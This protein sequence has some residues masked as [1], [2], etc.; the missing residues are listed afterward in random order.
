MALINIGDVVRFFND[1]GDREYV[2]VIDTGVVGGLGEVTVTPNL[3]FTPLAQRPYR[4]VSNIN[5]V[6]ANSNQSRFSSGYDNVCEYEVSFKESAKLKFGRRVTPEVGTQI[7]NTI[8]VTYIPLDKT[9]GNYYNPNELTRYGLRSFTDEIE[10][11]LTREQIDM[12]LRIIMNPAPKETFILKS[13]RRTPC[14]VGWIVNFNVP[15]FMEGS[16]ITT[17]VTHYLIK[18]KINESYRIE[19]DIEFSNY[20]YELSDLLNTF[21]NKYQSLKSTTDE[22][23]KIILSDCLT[24]ISGKDTTEIEALIPSTPTANTATNITNSSFTANWSASTGAVGYFITYDG[25]DIDVGN[26][27]YFDFIEVTGLTHT[28][29]VK[30]YNSKGISSSSLTIDVTLT[31]TYELITS[32]NTVL[33]INFNTVSK[34]DWDDT[35][36]NNN[37]VITL[38][39]GSTVS[40]TDNLPTQNYHALFSGTNTGY[41]SIY[42]SSSY[43]LSGS[44]FTIEAIVRWRS[45]NGS[46]NGLCTK[47]YPGGLYKTGEWDIGYQDTDGF[48]PKGLMFDM[49]DGAT[50]RLFTHVAE[51]LDLNSLYYLV[52]TWKQSTKTL[53]HYINKVNKPYTIRTENVPGM[54]EITPITSFRTMTNPTGSPSVGQHIE[55]LLGCATWDIINGFSNMDMYLFAIHKEEIT[56]EQITTNYYNFF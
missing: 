4:V 21:K 35:T 22:Q 8:V 20:R 48:F 44:D 2:T 49:H 25:V 24:F 3:T 12:I 15:Y 46:F 42:D 14:Q 53:K 26:V 41:C 9:G 18:N 52:I 40:D 50:S 36:S 28:Y 39:A 56:Q 51:E 54:T 31:K 6:K 30:A 32:A 29:S 33:N 1:N 55:L 27:L 5:L 37:D 47:G 43:S 7:Q 45:F 23:N 11:P 19:Q 34:N 17:A 10:F 16:F 13:Y 38:G